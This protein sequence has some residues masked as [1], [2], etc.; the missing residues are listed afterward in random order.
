MMFVVCLCSKTHCPGQYVKIQFCSA[1][2]PSHTEKTKRIKFSLEK[3][4]NITKNSKVI[5]MHLI[6]QSN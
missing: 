6:W 5:E 3:V 4:L 1:V 2:N